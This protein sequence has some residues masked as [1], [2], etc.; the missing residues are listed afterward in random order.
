MC[1]PFI[2]ARSKVTE[3]D[4]DKH[5]GKHWIWMSTVSKVQVGWLLYRAILPRILPSILL[6]ILPNTLNM[7]YHDPFLRSPF[8]KQHM[9]RERDIYIYIYMDYHGNSNHFVDTSHVKQPLFLVTQVCEREPASRWRS[10]WKS[11][12]LDLVVQGAVPDPLIVG[13]SW[14]NITGGFRFVMGVPPNHG[15][16]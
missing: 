2:P 3:K 1:F 9:E 13:M 8:T 5:H 14:L 12:Q 11:L 15:V 6:N 4:I 10:E 7:I 16:S